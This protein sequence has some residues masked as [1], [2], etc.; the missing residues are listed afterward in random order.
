MRPHQ[1][2]EQVGAITPEAVAGVVQ[3][4]ELRTR[5]ARLEVATDRHRADRIAVG[6]H[7]Q[8]GRLN[9]GQPLGEVARVRLGDERLRM[10]KV[11]ALLVAPVLDVEA[12]EVD[13]A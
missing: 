10:R 5:Q 2:G 13:A 3:H 12:R 8:R 11:G 9:L 4:D 7:Q 1:R 6:P